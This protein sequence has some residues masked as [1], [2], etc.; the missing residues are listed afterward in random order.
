M[1]D[2]SVMDSMVADLIEYDLQK[3]KAG[4]ERKYR[5]ALKRVTGLD[6]AT[7]D[8]YRA[9]AAKVYENTRMVSII[10]KFDRLGRLGIVQG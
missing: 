1:G 2:G 9:A 5:N 6:N 3:I 10:Y 4:S 8:D 7:D